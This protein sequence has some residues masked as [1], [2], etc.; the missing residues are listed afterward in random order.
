MVMDADGHELPRGEIGEIWIHPGSVIK[1]L[2]EQSDG[3]G[4]KFHRRVLAFGRS[5][6]D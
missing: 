5:R 6:F 3:D 4:G 2:L 1:R